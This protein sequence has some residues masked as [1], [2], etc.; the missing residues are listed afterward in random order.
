VLGAEGVAAA[1]ADTLTLNIV[2]ELEAV[3]IERGLLSDGSDPTDAAVAQLLVPQLIAPRPPDVDQVEIDEWPLIGVQVRT[4]PMIR[5]VDVTD[6]EPDMDL[7]AVPGSGGVDYLVTYNARVSVWVRGDGYALVGAL[8]DRLML[9]TRCVLL[10]NQRIGA[11]QVVRLVE[12][13]L[14]E[15]Y[16]PVGV[17]ERLGAT[18]GAAFIDGQWT[19]DERLLMAS[20]GPAETID[21]P[22]G[23]L[24]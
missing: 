21:T 16:A 2:G 18:I 3:N 17:D 15:N 24:T 9:A 12:Q 11:T 13:Q 14:S 8:R 5:A 19:A 22:V 10:R 1:L 6:D 4:T 20:Y 23:L 7:A